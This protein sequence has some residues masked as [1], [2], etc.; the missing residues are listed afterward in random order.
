[1]LSI[2]DV[3]KLRINP[4]FEINFC[5]WSTL[6]SYSHVIPIH[7]GMLRYHYSSFCYHYIN[8]ISNMFLMDSKCFFTKQIGM[9]IMGIIVNNI[10]M[11][12]GQ[13]H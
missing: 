10:I 2:H 9:K 5:M 8:R 4:L 13:L 3:R 1:M 7:I 6:F 11:I 12:M